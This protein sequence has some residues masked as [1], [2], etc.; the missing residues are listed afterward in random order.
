MNLSRINTLKARRKGKESSISL[1]RERK[2]VEDL[3]V[4]YLAQQTGEDSRELGG[5]ERKR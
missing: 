1:K 3:C 5:M 2:E 4:T